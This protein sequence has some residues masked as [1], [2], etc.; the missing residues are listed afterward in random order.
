MKLGRGHRLDLAAQAAQRQPVDARQ[1]AAMAEFQF[2]FRQWRGISPAQDLAFGF[3]LRQSDSTSSNGNAS[4]RASR[5][6]VKGPIESIHP[7]RIASSDPRRGRALRRHPKLSAAVQDVRAPAS[8]QLL[9]VRLP[10]RHAE[11]QRS[12]SAAHR[13]VHRRREPPARIPRPPARSPP[14]PG[15]QRRRR[16]PRRVRRNCTARVRRSSS[17]ASSR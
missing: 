10:F 3:E 1:N 5:A 9:E 12:A 17:G 14:G 16:P 4:V 15:A 6:A 13:A 2:A 7:R 11:A 8:R